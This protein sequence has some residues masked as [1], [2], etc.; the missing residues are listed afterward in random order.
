MFDEIDFGIDTENEAEPQK[1]IDNIAAHTQ[2]VSEMTQDVTNNNDKIVFVNQ[3][4]CDTHVL[5]HCENGELTDSN[6]KFTI[7]K[8]HDM[9]ILLPSQVVMIELRK[10][11]KKIIV[12]PLKNVTKWNTDFTMVCIFY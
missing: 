1:I 3:I 11:D 12:P 2:L 4:N 5:Q 7:Q 6:A 10:M 9:C 8:V